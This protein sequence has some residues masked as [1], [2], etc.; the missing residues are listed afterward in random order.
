MHVFTPEGRSVFTQFRVFPISTSVDIT[1]YQYGR[2]VLYLF[3]DM[4][5]KNMHEVLEGNFLKFPV[6]TSSYINTALGQSAFRIYECYI[7]KLYINRK[8]MFYICFII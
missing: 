2:N 1:V 4:G 6:F 8:K 7:I 5:Q 3:Y